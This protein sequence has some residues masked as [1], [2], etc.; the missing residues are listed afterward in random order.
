M[1]ALS[2]DEY[3][4]VIGLDGV[5][6]PL[7]QYAWA[8]QSFGGSARGL[9]PLRG[10]NP[11][12]ANRPG[13]AFRA[14]TADSRTISL[15][16]FVNGINPVTNG[17]SGD[18]ELQFNQNLEGLQ[19]L[20][21]TPG[22][23]VQLVRRWR[24]PAGIRKGT[25]KAQISGTMDPEMTGRSRAT[26]QVDLLLADP[27]FYS[28]PVTVALPLDG[29]PVDVVNNGMVATT[30]FG[31]S[32]DIVGG[33]GWG[34]G[35]LDHAPFVVTSKY[36]QENIGY[37]ADVHA[38]QLIGWSRD[39]YGVAPGERVSWVLDSSVS[40]SDNHLLTDEVI[41]VSPGGSV[42]SHFVGSGTVDIDWQMAVNNLPVR[43][44]VVGDPYS[45]LASA[46]TYWL[47]EVDRNAEEFGVSADQS[48]VADTWAFTGGYPNAGLT[49][50]GV[51]VAGVWSTS[52]YV[53]AQ[54]PTSQWLTLWPGIN[55][56]SV[57]RADGSPMPG[58]HV[59]TGASVSVTYREPW[60]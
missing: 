19:A 21:W 54:G 6:V 29:T 13:Q 24:T 41:G 14:K 33:F 34:F 5:E 50:T 59:T 60:I 40:V 42:V 2:S 26:F 20:F 45:T 44:D 15:E 57:A 30:G 9:P 25:A 17:P 37:R 53:T 12:Y 55:K 38:D 47:A 46:H 52:G 32:V 22:D 36:Y 58:T 27:F 31:C 8:V 43:F 48:G 16:M 3:W 7:N 11:V 51:R 10:E 39:G 1:V 56:V 23:Q 28:D 35:A 4:S 18:S 49:L